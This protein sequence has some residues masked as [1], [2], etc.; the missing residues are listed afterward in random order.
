MD[1]H[2]TTHC[3]PLNSDGS[4]AVLS[5]VAGGRSALYTLVLIFAAAEE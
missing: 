2:D 5:P 3:I 4:L 1:S